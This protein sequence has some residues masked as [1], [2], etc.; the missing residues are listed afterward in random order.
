MLD[1]A[2]YAGKYQYRYIYISNA[3]ICNINVGQFVLVESMEKLGIVVICVP[4][5]ANL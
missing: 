1:Y 3:K 5:V 4:N 2:M